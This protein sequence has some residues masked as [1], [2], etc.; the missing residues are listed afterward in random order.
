MDGWDFY[1]NK[2]ECDI[3]KS[4]NNIE[5]LVI[6]VMGNRNKGKS[7]ILQALSGATLKTGT[8][9]NTI[10]ISIKYLDNKYVLLDCAGSE[11]PLLGESANMF[12][13][14]GTNY[15]QKLFLKVIFL[16]KAMFYCWL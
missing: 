2:D 4:T 14:Q 11:S 9:I 12:V 3:V 10:G 8:T 1:M 6:G 7:F 13:F 15:S 16:G 5:R